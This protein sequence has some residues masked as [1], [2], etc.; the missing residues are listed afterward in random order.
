MT[1]IAGQAFVVATLVKGVAFFSLL[2]G[3]VA[4]ATYAERRIAGFIQDRSGPNRVGPIGLLQALADGVK[5]IFKEETAPAEANKV[6]FYLAPMLAVAPATVLFA[7]IP[8]ASP[9]PTRWGLVELI[10]ADVPVGFL[11]ILALSSLGVYGVVM[12]GW[13]SN[14]KYA[15]LGGLRGSAQ[16]ISYEVALAMSLIPLLLLAGDVRIPEMISM[17]QGFAGGGT[18]GTWFVLPLGLSAFFFLIAGLAE[19]NRL[20]FDLPEAEAELVAGYHTEY[21]SMKFSMF[22]M[23]EYAHLITT[24][25]LVTVFFLGGWDIPF[26]N[27][28]NIRVLAD[29]RVIG[30]PAVWKTVLTFLSF[31]VKTAAVV[32]VFMWVRWTLPRFR[33]DQLMDLGWKFFIPAL[34]AYIVIIAASLYGLEAVGLAL[35]RGVALALFALNLLLGGILLFVVDRGVLIG[36]SGGRQR[37]GGS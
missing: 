12:A 36:G 2:M 15:F 24:A 26:W 18:M 23:G 21:S 17:Q 37:E 35:G 27:G 6:F 33:Y 9:F 5:F 22:F 3:L 28:D 34:M 13:S 8:F 29:G 32:F 11:Y 4:L 7:V 31:S 30:D 19:T 20:P 14:S 16:M 25:A 10:V 1:P